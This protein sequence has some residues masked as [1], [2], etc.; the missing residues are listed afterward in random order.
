MRGTSMNAVKLVLAF[1]FGMTFILLL[2][3][4]YNLTDVLT[5]NTLLAKQQSLQSQL[6]LANKKPSVPNQI[7]NAPNTNTKLK[8]KQTKCGETDDDFKLSG[9][10]AV[11]SLVEKVSKKFRSTDTSCEQTKF[12][13]P[14]SKLTPKEILGKQKCIRNWKK[15]HKMGSRS[16][17]AGNTQY[18]RHTHHTYINSDST[19]FD[20]G[21]NKGED[22]EA[23]LKRFNPGN[24]VI[25]EPVKTL[26]S[27]LVSMLKNKSNVAVYNFGLARKNNKFY[28]NVLGHGG[29][30]TSIFAGNDDG[31]SCLLRVVNTTQFLLH[32]GVP[33]YEVDLITINCEGCEFEIM[34]ELIG[35][36]MIGQFRNVQFATHP[37]LK[38]LK[39]PI[40]RYCEIQEK[41]K[42]THKVGYQYKWC[43]ESWKRKDLA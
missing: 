15:D 17:W 24:Y 41:L 32:V 21:G 1:V 29:D 25:L 28:V 37:T 10:E 33:C 22:A 43:W 18:I 13:K 4:W 26:F 19:V 27:N 39:Q 42:R 12:P 35:S 7:H 2:S 20:I 16:F 9:I 31:G 23:M 36:G 30:A 3:S 38:H 11:R 14:N 6:L 5:R 34:E 40:E 8:R